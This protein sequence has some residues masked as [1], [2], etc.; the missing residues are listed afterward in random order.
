LILHLLFFIYCSSIEKSLKLVVCLFLPMLNSI[1]LF[2][3]LPM[4]KI[5]FWR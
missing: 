3:L 2:K 4:S 5:D 1:Q